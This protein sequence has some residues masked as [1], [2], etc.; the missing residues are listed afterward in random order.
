M[1]NH[2][3]CLPPNMMGLT[4]EQISELKLIDEWGEVC[5]PSGGYK[6]NPDPVGRRNGKQPT[7]NMQNVLTRTVGEA[8][9]AISKVKN[10]T[11]H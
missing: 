4:E 7:E 3:T 5:I 10:K 1:A 2:G 6:D 9:A 11:L 8:K